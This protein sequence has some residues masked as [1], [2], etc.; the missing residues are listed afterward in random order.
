VGE[1]LKPLTSAR[2]L[3]G[4]VIAWIV[5][6]GIAVFLYLALVSGTVQNAGPV[7]ATLNRLR[8]MHI[9]PAWAAIGFVVLIGLLL[10]F[11]NRFIYGILEGYYGWGRLGRRR[12]ET[13]RTQIRVLTAE[14]RLAAADADEAAIRAEL[15]E[16][17]DDWDSLAAELR[18]AEKETAQAR[19]DV[20]TA[21]DLR[22]QRLLLPWRRERRIPFGLNA[23]LDRYPAD[24]QNARP[25]K[26]GNRIRAFETYGWER[27]RIE[28]LILWFQL[29]AVAPEELLQDIQ[30]ARQ[31]VEF[32]VGTVTTSTLLCLAS[33][34]SAIAAWAGL[35]PHHLALA[36]ML[37]AAGCALLAPLAYRLA[38]AQVEEWRLA[39]VALVDLARVP[40][41]E[42][43]G[44]TMPTDIT[45]E[46]DMW[47]AVSGYVHYGTDRY[48]QA[49]SEFRITK[50]SGTA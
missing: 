30:D 11:S 29:T 5:P 45:D 37:L 35:A 43:L 8:E 2:A 19:S 18:A 7:Q 9:N 28:T 16:G 32:F 12:T 23:S 42:R 50:P 26:L 31:N 6:T 14:F 47:Q 27:Y 48:A 49:V 20:A 36:P 3:L 39:V 22:A 34:L 40:L 44:L 10:A 1:L 38:V 46:R 24:E 13:H 4:V 21:I 17:P 41:A 15:A 25:S 33:V